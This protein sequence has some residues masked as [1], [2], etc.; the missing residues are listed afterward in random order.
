MAV[1]NDASSELQVSA[2]YN[3][4]LCIIYFFEYFAKI[5]FF[6]GVCFVPWK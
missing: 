2:A 4:I 1:T 3:V 5:F 6:V